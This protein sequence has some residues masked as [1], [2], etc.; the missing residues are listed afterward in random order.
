LGSPQ[1]LLFL[2]DLVN[3]LKSEN[4]PDTKNIFIR[5]QDCENQ[6]ILKTFRQI[7]SNTPGI[8]V[9]A[10]CSKGIGENFKHLLSEFNLICVVSNK[11]HSQAVKNLYHIK[12][13][14]SIESQEV[15]YKFVD[16]TP[17]SQLYLLETVVLFQNEMINLLNLMSK[18]DHDQP[19]MTSELKQ[20]DECFLEIVDDKLLK[21][22]VE[23]SS[24]H[25]NAKFECEKYFQTLHRPRNL[26]KCDSKQEFT[27]EELLKLVKNDRSV[28]ISDIVGSGKSWVLKSI[29]IALRKQKPAKWVSYIQLKMFEN[30][31]DFKKSNSNFLQFMTEHVLSSCNTFEQAIFKRLYKTGNCCVLLDGVDELSLS[32]REFLKELIKSFKNYG[33]NQIWMTT[34][35]NY[36]DELQDALNA[37]VV[38]KLTEFTEQDAIDFIKTTWMLSDLEREL[39]Y[40]KEADILKRLSNQD[41]QIYQSYAENLVSKIFNTKFLQTGLPNICKIAADIFKDQ[42]DKSSVYSLNVDKIYDE[43]VKNKYQDWSNGY[44]RQS[45]CSTDSDT[46][47]AIN[48][49]QAIKNVCPMLTPICDL[50]YKNVKF[51][52]EDVIACG[53]TSQRNDNIIFQHESFNEYF[54]LSFIAKVIKNFRDIVRESGFED[55]LKNFAIQFFNSRK[56]DIFRSVA[57]NAFNKIP[58]IDEVKQFFLKFFGLPNQNDDVIDFLFKIVDEIYAA[59]IKNQNIVM[60]TQVANNWFGEQKI[61]KNSLKFLNQFPEVSEGFN[62]AAN[63]FIYKAGRKL[64]Y[65]NSDVRSD[66]H[67]LCTLLNAESG[68]FASTFN[69]FMDRCS[70]GEQTR[71]LME[72]DKNQK[73]LLYMCIEKRNRKLLKL[74]WTAAEGR[75]DNF[76]DFK[77]IITKE[78]LPFKYNVF[79]AA[80][81]HNRKIEFHETFWTLAFESFKD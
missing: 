2:N 5:P 59:P 31:F 16:L 66:F 61:V 37:K 35:N 17:D 62:L 46:F 38:N 79:H 58:E 78:S 52:D 13:S 10:D 80:V 63:K 27:Q 55:I 32:S 51:H 64:L 18:P 60:L 49:Y 76:E 71:I 29:A 75:F 36:K 57:D 67:T 7:V 30:I 41:S 24:I 19:Q 45:S 34:R 33:G 11:L 47:L 39:K 42:D 65:S 43:Y 20:V 50:I 68:M 23:E 69:N 77:G 73:N 9:I 12:F 28:I 8:R 15:N 4:L 74:L 14:K 40:H 72:C 56:F 22:L 70:P 25:I 54:V 48:Q 1:P 6:S 81:V 21:L 53:L 26:I 44:R 3:R